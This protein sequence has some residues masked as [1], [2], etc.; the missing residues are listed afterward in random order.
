MRQASTRQNGGVVEKQVVSKLNDMIGSRVPFL[1]H[2]LYNCL[3]AL[4]LANHS[5]ASYH[6]AI[7]REHL[8]VLVNNFW[9]GRQSGRKAVKRHSQPPE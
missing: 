2:P 6:K 7:L 4:V 5:V 1:C 3:V 9:V 8:N